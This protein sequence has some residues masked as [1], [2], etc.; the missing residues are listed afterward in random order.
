MALN[1]QVDLPVEKE[2]KAG[3]RLPDF[4]FTSSKGE[5]VALS[6]FEGKYVFID[7]WATWCKPCLHENTFTDILKRRVFRPGQGFS[8]KIPQR[9]ARG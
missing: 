1:A 3:E 4:E 6:D 2:I 5:Q 7:I 8:C 9:I